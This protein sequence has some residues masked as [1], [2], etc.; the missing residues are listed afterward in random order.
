MF[1]SYLLIRKLS[2]FH[3]ADASHDVIG[4]NRIPVFGSPGDRFRMQPHSVP[5]S[6]GAQR[7]VDSKRVI[8]SSRPGL[9]VRTGS[10]SVAERPKF[11]FSTKR[12]GVS[13]G[14]LVRVPPGSITVAGC[15]PAFANAVLRV[16]VIGAKEKVIRIDTRR[17][18]ASMAHTHSG[19]DGSICKRVTKPVSKHGKSVYAELAVSVSECSSVPCPATVGLCDLRPESNQ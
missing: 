15:P 12:M 1:V 16:V 10:V 2:S 11:G 9:R 13:T 14:D 4:E 6:S 18:V 5:V 19:R 7:G 3:R 17:V 8:A